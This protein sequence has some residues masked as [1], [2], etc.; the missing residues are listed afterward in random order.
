M[1]SIFFDSELSKQQFIS[2]FMEW[3]WGFYPL[4]IQKKEDKG[5]GVGIFSIVQ[6]V[7]DYSKG[8]QM[9]QGL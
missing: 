9:L 3:G 1:C 7:M 8:F 5:G 6:V 2:A 4:K